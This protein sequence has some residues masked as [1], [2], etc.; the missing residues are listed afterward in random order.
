V[1]GNT[2]LESP[3][4]WGLIT[5]VARTAWLVVA[6]VSEPRALAPMSVVAAGLGVGVGAGLGVAVGGMLTFPGSTA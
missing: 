4:G 2:L 5:V 1:S 3:P 6:A